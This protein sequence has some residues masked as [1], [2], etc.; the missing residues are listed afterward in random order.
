[1]YSVFFGIYLDVLP[2]QASHHPWAVS[3][4]LLYSSLRL[5]G[6]RIFCYYLCTYILS[7]LVFPVGVLKHSVPFVVKQQKSF[8]STAKSYILLPP[9]KNLFP[10]PYLSGR[11]NSPFWVLCFSSCTESFPFRDFLKS[12]CTCFYCESFYTAKLGNA[13]WCKYRYYFCAHFFKNFCR[14]AY[15]NFSGPEDENISS[16]PWHL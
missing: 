5:I 2:F 11:K 13:E 16:N 8:I 14:F 9:P 12:Q 7:P 1:M 6:A 4:L 3:R 10:L 15:Q